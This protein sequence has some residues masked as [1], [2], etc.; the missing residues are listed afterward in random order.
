MATLQGPARAGPRAAEFHPVVGP[1]PA[2]RPR[3]LILSA[4]GGTGHLRAAEAV[5][6]ALREVA[7]DAEVRNLDAFSLATPLFRLLYAD[8]Y[9]FA[10]RRWP[11]FVGLMYNQVDKPVRWGD[12]T[13]YKM[14]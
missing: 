10:V 11:T 2:G 3:V 14:Q 12:S 13:M 1:R 4:S 9:R 5:A 7:P 6:L 8:A